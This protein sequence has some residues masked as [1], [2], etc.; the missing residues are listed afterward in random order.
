MRTS[1]YVST[2]ISV[3]LIVFLNIIHHPL[4]IYNTQSFGDWILL[5]LQVETTHFGPIDRTS[6]CLRTPA[7]T[8]HK[9]VP[10]LN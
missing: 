10:V 9:V 1:T 7:P 6:P 4:F 5:R 2:L 8:Q 3:S